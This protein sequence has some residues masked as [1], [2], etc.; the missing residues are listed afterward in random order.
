MLTIIV[1]LVTGVI[2]GTVTGGVLGLWL[3]HRPP[4]SGRSLDDLS[5]DPG[6][7]ARITAASVRWAADKGRPEAAG[8]MA[9]KA[10]LL[11]ALNERRSRRRRWTP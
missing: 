8:L 6:L 2:S 9:K 3:T 7:D 4:A 5:I 10:R 1:A 11:Y